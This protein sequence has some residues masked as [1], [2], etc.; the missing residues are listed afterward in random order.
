MHCT[1]CQREI[2]DYSN[3]CSFCGARQSPTVAPR[4]LMRSAWDKKIAGVCSG[5]SEHFD[6]DPTIFRIIFVFVTLATGL[7]PG[8]IAYIV[9]WI[10]MPQAPYVVTPAGAP[11]SAA[12]QS[13]AP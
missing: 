4:R 7:L 5:F 9:A 12:P 1:A 13:P 8:I 6:M 3:F 10:L 11:H 2:T